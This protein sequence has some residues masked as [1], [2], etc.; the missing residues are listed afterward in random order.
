L[1]DRTLE[2]LHQMA[3]DM[4]KSK[5]RSSPQIGIMILLP[6]SADVVW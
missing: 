6:G 1:S 3:S 5:R 4:N 2:I